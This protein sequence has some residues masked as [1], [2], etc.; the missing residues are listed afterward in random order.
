MSLVVVASHRGNE[1]RPETTIQKPG[2]DVDA[3]IQAAQLSAAP[4]WTVSIMLFTIH[5]GWR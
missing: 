1:G 3:K 2:I 4:S 5:A